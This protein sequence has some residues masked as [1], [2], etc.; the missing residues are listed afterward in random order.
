MLCRQLMNGSRGMTTYCSFLLGAQSKQVPEYLRSKPGYG[1]YRGSRTVT[2]KWLQAFGR[3]LLA[4]GLLCER[5]ITG[6]AFGHVTAL[7]DSGRQ[8]LIAN[9]SKQVLSQLSAFVLTALACTFPQKNCVCVTY[10]YV[11]AARF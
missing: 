7:T 2:L 8:W 4:V 5:P 9:K 11:N 10:K 6:Y 1:R 3:Q